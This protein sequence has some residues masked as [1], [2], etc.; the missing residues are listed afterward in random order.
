MVSCGEFFCGMDRKLASVHGLHTAKVAAMNDATLKA[1][2]KIDY[3]TPEHKAGR[4][5]GK[6][7]T[8]RLTGVEKATKRLAKEEVQIDEANHRDYACASCMHPTMAKHMTVGQHTDYYEPKTGNK[9]HGKVM[10]K[11]DTEV[12]MKQTQ[13]SYDDKKVGSVHKFKIKNSLDEV[14]KP[15]MGAGTYVKD[16]RKSKAPQFKGKSKAKKQDMAVAAYLGAKKSK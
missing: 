5:L 14:L 4:A 9:V 13:D 11:R 8:K 2:K 12:H 1:K 15:S 7:W 10:H 6:K 3:D 16:F